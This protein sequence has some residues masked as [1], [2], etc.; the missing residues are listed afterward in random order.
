[1]GDRW[2]RAL[3]RTIVIV[4]TLFTLAL[5]VHT[6]ALTAVL[7]KG[8]SEAVDALLVDVVLKAEAQDGAKLKVSDPNHGPPRCARRRARR[9]VERPERAGFKSEVVNL[10]LPKATQSR[11]I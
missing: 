5:L 9:K 6:S 7:F 4:N 1:M 3:F 2:K 10:P 8:G 11:S